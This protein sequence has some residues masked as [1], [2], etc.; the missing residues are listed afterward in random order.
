MSDRVTLKIKRTSNNKNKCC[1]P[2]CS[3]KT[4][5][6]KISAANRRFI[7][8]QFKVFVPHLAVACEQHSILESWSNVTNSIDNTTST[9]STSNIEEMFQLLA[10]DASKNEA[11]EFCKLFYCMI[12]SLFEMKKSSNSVFRL[13]CSD[14]EMLMLTGH[15]KIEFK[16]LLH[17]CASLRAIKGSSDALFMYLMK[18][19]TARTQQDIGFYFKISDRT[20]ST[21]IAVVRKCLVTDIAAKYLNYSRTRDDLLSHKTAI[22]EC[23]FGQGAQL[24]MDGTYLYIQKSKDHTFQKVTFNNHKKRNYI[25]I[26]MGTAPDGEII[27]AL[28]PY[29]AVDNDATITKQILQGNVEAMRN[30]ELGDTVIVDRG[31]RDCEVDLVNRG[32][33][34]KMPACST[35][36]QLTTTEANQSRLVTKVR[37]DIERLN[38]LMKNYWKIFA[39]V[40]DTH[41]TPHIA[42]DFE[43][44]AALLNRKRRQQ[45]PESEIKIAEGRRVAGC[46]LGRMDEP[47]VLKPIVQANSFQSII[48][49]KAYVLFDYTTFPELSMHDLENLSFGPY[50]IEQ[51]K[52]YLRRHLDVNGTF[53]VFT[54]N[55]AVS[56]QNLKTLIDE[57]PGATLVMGELISRFVSSRKHCAFVL[58]HPEK[59][60]KEAVLHYV[61]ACKVGLRTVGMCSHVMAIIYFLG[62]AQYNGGVKEICLHLKNMFPVE[63]EIEEESQYESE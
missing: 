28:G 17:E 39:S 58:F 5:L 4:G 23:L 2:S 20:V 62:Y 3:V 45:T 52:L 33:I 32:F 16:Q 48:R 61:C 24:I 34:V 36:P 57:N 59:T 14:E 42:T 56:N 63:D 37:Y 47:N 18:M 38:G 53:N 46:M 30:Y 11:G 31:F 1:Y 9:F 21:K 27:F 50:Q 40:C 44:C 13:D 55:Q 49:Q 26:M 15:S 41:H 8:T 25:K 7:T 22:S 51:A 54:F 29:R 6:K 19:R 12:Y 43:I 60:G 10:N 35:N